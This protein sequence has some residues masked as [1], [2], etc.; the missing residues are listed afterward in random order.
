MNELF[1]VNNKIS[2]IDCLFGCTLA[3]TFVLKEIDV[4][5]IKPRKLLKDKITV[6]QAFILSSLDDFYEPKKAIIEIVND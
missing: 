6:E 3:P 5:K 1:V 4:V 2:V